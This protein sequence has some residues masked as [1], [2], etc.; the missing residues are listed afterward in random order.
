MNKS[1]EVIGD[2]KV[3][4]SPMKKLFIMGFL[5]ISFLLA[6]KNFFS[7]ADYFNETRSLQDSLSISSGILK[8]YNL[9]TGDL[10]SRIPNVSFSIVKE[11]YEE[12][13]QLSKDNFKRFILSETIILIH[14]LNDS[15]L[16][17]ERF[18]FFLR[19]LK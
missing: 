6:M 12:L 3:K 4:D 1:N 8:N 15:I 2:V 11:I 14:R 9:G 17:N 19:R 16:Q 7:Y 13:N 5:L 10:E 18:I